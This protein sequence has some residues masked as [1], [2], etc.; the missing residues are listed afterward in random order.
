MSARIYAALVATTLLGLASIGPAAADSD[1]HRDIRQIR[2]D[3]DRLARDDAQDRRDQHRIAA[4]KA[5]VREELREGDI[6]GAV[7]AI[8]AEHHDKQ[9]LRADERKDAAEA[10]KLNRD[11]RDLRRDEDRR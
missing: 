11:V 1:T 10:A 2:K 8:V 5:R 4:D 3:A 9:V 7:H 6:R